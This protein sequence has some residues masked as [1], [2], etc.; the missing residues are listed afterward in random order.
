MKKK[1]SSEALI[2][3]KAW[4]DYVTSLSPFKKNVVIN[5]FEVIDGEHVYKCDADKRLID[6]VAREVAEIAEEQIEALLKFR[7]SVSDLPTGQ[8]ITMK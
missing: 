1:L 6:E 8:Y 4:N 3:E 5:N 7:S 2:Y